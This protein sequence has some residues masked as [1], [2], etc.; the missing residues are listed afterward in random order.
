[1]LTKALW[2]ITSHHIT[3]DDAA[4]R[5]GDVKA[6]PDLFSAF[7]GY[8]DFKRKKVK[9][10]QLSQTDL[11]SHAGAL[12]GL[13]NKPYMRLSFFANVVTDIQL[14]ADCL[15]SYAEHLKMK[16]SE[17]KNNASLDFPVRTIDS[18]TTVEF[19]DKTLVLDPRYS[20]LDTAVRL[21]GI[22]NP[23]VIDEEVHLSHPFSSGAQRL[24]FFK[25]MKL[26]VP[27]D[28]LKFNPGGGLTTT[29]CVCQV[30]G[31]AET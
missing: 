17:T 5:S 24:R 21:A 26:T 14:L 31:N 15:S 28:M 8:N 9:A 25:N 20:V 6:V 3:I 13:L 2:C 7:S 11:D 4:R 10:G 27:I 22:G 30:G 29:V 16:L 18:H 12:F 23:L 1:M 19:K